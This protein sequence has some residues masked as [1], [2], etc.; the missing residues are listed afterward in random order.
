MRMWILS[1]ICG[2][3]A[4]LVYADVVVAQLQ[5]QADDENVVASKL[6]G[7]W[8]RDAELTKRLGGTAAA[9]FSFT[10]DARVAAKIPAK[11]QS[12][13]TGKQVY[14]AGVLTFRDKEYPF[15]LIE[16]KGNPH[17]VYFRERDGDPLGD[18]ESFN[19]MLAVGKDK[20]D[21]LLFMGGDFNNQPFTAYRRVKTDT[22]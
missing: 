21:D 18:A 9:K 8:E 11:Y 3:L 7:Q 10:S 1:G 13:F 5:V 16:H 22:K 12:F 15:I 19:V 20:R 4:A 6:E 17:V 2:F 14:M